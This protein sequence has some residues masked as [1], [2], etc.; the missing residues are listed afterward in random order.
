MLSGLNLGAF[1][2]VDFQRGRIDF[3]S[4]IK[5]IVPSRNASSNTSVDQRMSNGERPPRLSTGL[6]PS[7]FLKRSFDNSTVVTDA[8]MGYLAAQST[9]GSSSPTNCSQYNYSTDRSVRHKQES[10]SSYVP[11]SSLQ[12]SIPGPGAVANMMSYS[13]KTASTGRTSIESAGSIAAFS[14][15]GS[16][17]PDSARPIIGKMPLSPIP[18]A[19]RTPDAPPVVPSLGLSALFSKPAYFSAPVIPFPTISSTSSSA[20][21]SKPTIPKTTQRKV[22]VDVFARPTRL[23]MPTPGVLE[24]NIDPSVLRQYGEVYYV[25]PDGGNPIR[26]KASF[27]APPASVPSFEPVQFMLPPL[28]QRKT[29][30]RK[31]SV[32]SQVQNEIEYFHSQTS[33]ESQSNGR[34]S[35]SPIAAALSSRSD[36]P[37]HDFLLESST[38]VMNADGFG[39]DEFLPL[40]LEEPLL[41]ARGLLA[42]HASGTKNKNHSANIHR[43]DSVS[44]FGRRRTPR[45]DDQRFFLDLPDGV[46]D[47]VEGLDEV[48]MSMEERDILRSLFAD[49]H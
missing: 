15:D 46:T 27:A 42:L 47:D 38:N 23:P 20:T 41:S 39:A 45:G 7:F 6:E 18:S 25:P 31:P 9:S 17:L 34:R 49:M 13:S 5:R 3:L 35:L 8:S 16:C 29:Q 14:D 44:S 30:Q 12:L 28:N 40:D 19:V 1:F 10:F 37:A 22:Q 21:V 26:I 36:P 33:S 4:R 24:I 2:N 48:N 11:D 32:L 43:S